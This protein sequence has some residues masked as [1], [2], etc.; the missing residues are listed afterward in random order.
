M[1]SWRAAVLTVFMIA[2]ATTATV[3]P[4][5]AGGPTSVLLV[6]PGTGETASLY[7]SDDDYQ[8]LAGLVGAFGTT[9]SE[10]VEDASPSPTGRTVTVTWLIHDVQVWR[11][12]RVYLDAEGGPLVATQQAL[13]ARSVDQAPVAWIRPAAGK[14]LAELLDRLGLAGGGPAPGGGPVPGPQP[15]DER[16]EAGPADAAQPPVPAADDTGAPPAVW[17]LLGSLLGVTLALSASRVVA[18][19][20]RSGDDRTIDV[21]VA[22]DV[23]WVVTDELSSTAPP[24]R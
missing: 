11:V 24:R 20:R 15:G 3:A 8:A 19:R 21:A 2:V 18:G 17:V 5:A 6:A 23:D 12:D 14:K 9:S 10:A 4:V 13:D 22:P 7:A 16:L 1:R